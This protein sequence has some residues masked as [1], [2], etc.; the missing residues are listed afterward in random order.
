MALL[1]KL[2]LSL[3]FLLSMNVQAYL[4][5]PSDANNFEGYSDSVLYNKFYLYY[6]TSQNYAAYQVVQKEPGDFQQEYWCI[7][8]TQQEKTNHINSCNDLI[9]SKNVCPISIGGYVDGITNYK[10]YLDPLTYMDCTQDGVCIDIPQTL[11]VEL[12]SDDLVI[13][14]GSAGLYN[15]YS[16]GWVDFEFEGNSYSETGQVVELP[17]FYKQ[18]VD[19]KGN[20]INN[21]FDILGT[22]LGVAIEDADLLYALNV[23]STH[24]NYWQYQSASAMGTPENFIVNKSDIKSPGGKIGPFSPNIDGL[25]NADN[26]AKVYVYAQHDANPTSQSGEYKLNVT[27][28]VTAHERL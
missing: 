14:G 2:L 11:S 17:Y 16:N 7:Y 8:Q 22:R 13:N 9:G 19:A 20:L 23:N 10:P 1:K 27:L 6:A 15:V 28:T 4:C 5:Q 25:Y 3:S 12:G 24:K 18:E 21:R 26:Y